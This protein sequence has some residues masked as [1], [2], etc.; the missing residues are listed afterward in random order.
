MQTI[1]VKDK[2]FSLFISEQHISQAIQEVAEK[3]NAD[4]HD[5]FPLFVGVLNGSFM[6]VGELLKNIQMP[7]EVSF[8]KVAS[9]QGTTS[10]GE[11]KKLIGFN[12]KIKG[13]TV[14]V[15]EDIID[16]GFTM[17]AVMEEL[18]QYEPAEIKLATLLFKPTAFKKNYHIHYIALEI[19]DDFVLGFG[20]DYDGLG[21]NY[22]DI[23]K[24]L[25][26]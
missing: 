25:N 17:E 20:L 23:Y 12:E 10:G 21:R 11:L 24:I 3:I 5:K 18:K 16:T 13:R 4:L 2:D 19:P 7:C 1:T 22:R 6:F 26:Q 15:C 9:Y 14:V 8:I